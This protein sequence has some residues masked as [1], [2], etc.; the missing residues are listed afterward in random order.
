MKIGIIGSGNIG[1]A[2]TRRFR[3][4]GHEVSVSNSRGPASLADFAKETGARAVSVDDRRDEA[5]WSS[6][7]SRSNASKI[8]RQGS[9]AARR[10]T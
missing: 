1:G 6:S 5:T 7:R 2:L 8:Y 4:V 9:S 3:S 10:Q